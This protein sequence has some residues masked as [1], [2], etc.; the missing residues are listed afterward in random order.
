MDDW[1]AIGLGLGGNLRDPPAMIAAALQTLAERGHVRVTAVSTVYRT[2]PWGPVA[3]PDF[4][5][6]CAL[7]ATEL[8]PDDLLAEVKAVERA[9]GRGAS[10]RW[11]P[12]SIDIDILFYA[13][14]S[15]AAPDLVIPH[16]S[17]F[18]RAF[19]LVPLAEIA[20]DLVI[21]GRRVGD[22]ARVAAREGILPWR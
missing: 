20:P 22:A 19:V 16:A 1:V 12:R 8:T 4:A 17:L 18:E 7:A 10:E 11:G 21:T 14:A 6:A 3:Q 9:L 5:N 2:P 13:G 15:V